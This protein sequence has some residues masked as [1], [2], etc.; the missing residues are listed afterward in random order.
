MPIELTCPCG[1]RLRVSDAFAGQQGRCPACGRR[2]RIP[3]RE[4][5]SAGVASSPDELEQAVVAAPGSAGPK[6]PGA[7]GDAATPP[8]K[9]AADSHGVGRGDV[10]EGDGARLT[11]VG[12]AVTLLT[13]AVILGVALPV[14]RWRDLATGQ[15]LPRLVAIIVPFLLGAC[16]HGVCAALLRLV[17]LRIWSRPG[18]DDPAPP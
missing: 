5:P 2:L 16:F 13:A 1:R 11:G 12:C 15:P 14:V 7:P 6:G 9:F 8:A 4:A 10:G 18:K 17:G 3:G